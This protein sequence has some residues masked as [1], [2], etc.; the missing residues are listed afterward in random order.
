MIIA[1]VTAVF[2]SVLVF[3][4]EAIG[5]S[6]SQRT[7]LH[8]MDSFTAYTLERNEWVFNFPLTPGWIMWGA[9]DHVTL[10]LDGECWLGGVPSINAR[11]RFSDQSGAVPS[12]A[13]ESMYQYLPDTVNLLEDYE[14]LNVK[15]TGNSWYN[16]VNLSWRFSPKICL[17]V[18]PGVTYSETLEIDNGQRTPFRSTLHND[19]VKGDISI[20]ID[21]LCCDWLSV[22][23]SVSRGT[24]FVYLDNV[25]GK[26]QL[27]AGVRIAPFLQ[28][29]QPF[30][31]NMGAELAL[32]SISF[33]DVDETLTGPM[34]YLY[35][36]W[37]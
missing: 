23:S 5:N 1:R 21:W 25:P 2:L 29:Q 37:K 12:M 32:V 11:V 17:N 24:T 4:C 30:L 35:W 33:P 26:D 28:M 27:V 16:R 18:S 3:T 9:T 6:P 19:V 14:Y 8:P 31:R 20:G 13:F 36:Q 10:E 15:R 34:F 22:H 7:L